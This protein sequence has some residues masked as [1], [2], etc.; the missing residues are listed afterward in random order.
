MRTARVISEPA[1]DAAAYALLEARFHR[2]VDATEAFLE[3]H[4]S[5]I[6]LACRDMAERFERGGRL[7]AFGI[8]GGVS[9]AQHVAVEF[10]HP[11]LV[12][13]RALPAM[14]I[15]AVT[16]AA[17]LHALGRGTDIV[18][19]ITDGAP[20]AAMCAALESAAGKG[21]LTL[22]LSASGGP[23][24]RMADYHFAVPSDDPMITQE[25]LETAYHVMWELVHVFLENGRE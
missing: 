5:A 8:G 1:Q 6:S 14:S 21:M 24:G 18:F 3:G 20:D 25:T 7:F 9:D 15:N 23:S 10:V 19:C 4:A 2:S 13:K 12:G 17:E 16:A 22:L 11:V